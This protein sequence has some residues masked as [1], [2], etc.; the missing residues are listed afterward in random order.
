MSPYIPRIY[1]TEAAVQ[2]LAYLLIL[3]AALTMPIDSLA[4]TGYFTIRSGGKTFLTFL[5]DS[6]YSW[7][8]TIPLAWCLVHF[9]TLPIVPLY[10][11]VRFS[12]II[13]S[14]LGLVLVHKG[15]WCQNIVAEEQ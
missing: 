4:V 1:K 15:I 6:A 7:V 5:F 8:I 10:F 12:G 14:G 2:E 9:T 11:I 13:K 3:C